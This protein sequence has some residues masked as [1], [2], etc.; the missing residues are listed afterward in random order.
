MRKSF[1]EEY[2]R[3]MDSLCFTDEAKEA[4]VKSLTSQS[5]RQ[6]KGKH[7]M[8]KAFYIVLAAALLTA[9]MTGAAVYARWADSL[10]QAETT[11]K[12]QR[13]EAEKTGLSTVPRQAPENGD[14]TSVTKN[15][16]TISVRQTLA[17]R[18]SARLVFTVSGW[19]AP[20]GKQPFLMPELK[21]EGDPGSYGVGGEIYHKPF[22]WENHV[23]VYPDGTPVPLDKDGDPICIYETEA[24]DIELMLTINAQDL[25]NCFGKKVYID[26][27]DLGISERTEYKPLL[28]GPWNL[29]WTLTGSEDTSAWDVEK[30]IGDTGIVL[31]EVTLS[32]LSIEVL[33]QLPEKFEG[34][35]TLEP[36]PLV[37]AG[38]RTK[39]GQEHRE[40]SGGGMDLYEDPEKGLYRISRS[41]DSIL[42]SE[43]I[44]AILFVEWDQ[45]GK[46]IL[47][48]VDL[49]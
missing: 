22:Q 35:D 46:E 10:P 1:K 43:Q 7:T 2:S 9:T 34:F 40:L 25:K 26:I 36:F 11:T 5:V 38:Y 39:D 12:T 24:G 41:S 29:T 14:I 47:Y 45:K 49:P 18:T 33:L 6:E 48:T 21:F 4:M 23:A 13:Q 8:K 27:P 3:S 37:L 30:P 44:T 28:K 31:K 19:K 20:E 42:D 17:D 15:G 16:V 32:P